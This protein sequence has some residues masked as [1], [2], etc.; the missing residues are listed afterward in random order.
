M[1]LK[2]FASWELIAFTPLI[3][4]SHFVPAHTSLPDFGDWGKMH[5]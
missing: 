3:T 2:Y 1:S 5:F 4:L